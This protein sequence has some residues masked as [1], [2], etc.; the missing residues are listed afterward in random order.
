MSYLLHLSADYK[1]EQPVM[2]D[3]SQIPAALASGNILYRGKK[4]S[5]EVTGS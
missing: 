4:R 3:Y 2:C 5:V 1:L